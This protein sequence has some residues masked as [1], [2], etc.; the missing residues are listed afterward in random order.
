MLLKRNIGMF[1]KEVTYSDVSWTSYT[2]ERFLNLTQR[3]V[4][5]AAYIWECFLMSLHIGRF[6]NGMFPEQLTQSSVSWKAY[7]KECFLN[8]LHIGRRHEQLARRSFSWTAYTQDC[9]QNSLHIGIFP[10]QITH[11][12][13]SWTAYT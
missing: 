6:P 13:V 3:Y 8:S 5:R 7:T 2:K 12:N 4:F 9:F 11:R 1:P 10:Q